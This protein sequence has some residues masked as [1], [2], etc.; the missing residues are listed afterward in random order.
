[1][2]T[3]QDN[4]NK[5]PTVGLNQHILNTVKKE[6]PLKPRMQQSVGKLNQTI[7]KM[8]YMF[9]KLQE[10][11]KKIFKRIVE[12][13]QRHDRYTSKILANELIEI[14][15]NENVLTNIKL[16]LEQIQ[17]RLSTMNELGDAMVSIGPAIAVLRSMGPALSKFMPQAGAEFEAMSGL[18]GEIT[19]DSFGGDFELSDTSNEETD[20]ILKE[21]AVI[22]GNRVGEKFPSSPA[23]TYS[24]MESRLNQL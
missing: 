18:L 10:K 2:T 8:D 6:P 1:M 24:Q 12:S 20:A 5:P 15:K 7:S 14:R 11:D 3:F 13:Q 23:T 16:A 19:S 4:W 21:A 9:K 17:I 22:A